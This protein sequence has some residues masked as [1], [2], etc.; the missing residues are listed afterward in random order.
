MIASDTSSLVAYLRG[1]DGADVNLLDSII[2]SGQLVLPPVVVTEI[3]SGA[4]SAKALRAALPKIELLTILEGYWER[5]GDM[6]RLLKQNGLTAKTA[7]ALVAQSCIDHGVSLVTRG[8]DFRHFK[9][10]CGL[11]LA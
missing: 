4:E 5:A 8:T 7:G 2:A 3:L 9:K 10:Y 1:L 6:R 11:A